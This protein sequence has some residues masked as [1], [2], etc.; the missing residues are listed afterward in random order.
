MKI[1]SKIVD[2]TGMTPTQIENGLNTHLSLGWE[3]I[4]IVVISTKVYA[5]LTKKIAQ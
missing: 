2:I 3:L 5:L 1:K 4:Q